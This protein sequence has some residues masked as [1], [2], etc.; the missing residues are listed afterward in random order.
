MQNKYQNN[1]MCKRIPLQFSFLKLAQHSYFV[2]VFMYF[3]YEGI[4][5]IN[6]KFNRILTVG[7][8]S[9]YNY[10]FQFPNT[11]ALLDKM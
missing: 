8:A 5:Q 10:I 4:C 6:N 7:H 3:L 2:N 11:H 9:P 1:F